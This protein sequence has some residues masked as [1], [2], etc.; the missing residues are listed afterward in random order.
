MAK[1]IR[2]RESMTGISSTEL[3]TAIGVGI[4]MVLLFDH[5]HLI[6]SSHATGRIEAKATFAL[7]AGMLIIIWSFI[8]KK[9]KE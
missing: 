6:S 1:R 8:V 5:F 2:K 3:Y 9:K 4:G 7:G